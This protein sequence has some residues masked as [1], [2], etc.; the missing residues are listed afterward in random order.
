MYN[1][2]TVRARVYTFKI[3][4]LYTSPTPSY[5]Y[6]LHAPRGLFGARDKPPLIFVRWILISVL[7]HCRIYSSTPRR[8]PIFHATTTPSSTARVGGRVKNVIA[9]PAGDVVEG[10]PNLNKTIAS[11]ILLRLFFSLASL[12]VV[13]HCYSLRR[14]FLFFRINNSAT[15]TPRPRSRIVIKKLTVIFKFFVP[16]LRENGCESKTPVTQSRLTN[17]HRPTVFIIWCIP[18][19]T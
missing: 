13:C 3:A 19:Y 9:V 15:R 6:T 2:G 8:T 11:R 10:F 17:I 18:V 7:I 5:V 1:I 16:R 12:P 4:R 14:R